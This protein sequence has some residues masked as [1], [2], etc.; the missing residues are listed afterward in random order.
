[1][2]LKQGY[3]RKV[4]SANIRDLKKAGKPRRQ[5]VAAALSKAGKAKRKSTR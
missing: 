4:V 3:S 5:A 2:P 1:M